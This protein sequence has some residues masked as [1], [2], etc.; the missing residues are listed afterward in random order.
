MQSAKTSLIH[1]KD[2]QLIPRKCAGGA[3][4]GGK[5]I[6]SIHHIHVGDLE[7]ELFSRNLI[8]LALPG[9]HT[10]THALSLFLLFFE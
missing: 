10:Y 6:K 4:V 1:S 8:P 2:S 7:T 3:H 5:F 9:P